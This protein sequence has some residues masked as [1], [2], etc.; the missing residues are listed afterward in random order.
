MALEFREGTYG[1]YYTNTI[2]TSQA[3]NYQQMSWNAVYIYKS[4]TEKGYSLNAICAMLGNF[5]AESTINPGRWQGNNVGG[6]P[7]YGLAQWDPYSKY[8]DWCNDNNLDPTEMDSAIARIEYEYNNHIQ[9]YATDTYPISFAQFKVSEESLEYLTQAWV[10]N[11]ERPAVKPQPYRNEYSK[12]WYD[13]LKD[14]FWIRV[15]VTCEPIEGGTVSGAG[16]YDKNSSVTVS[17][18]TNTGYRFKYWKDSNQNIISYDQTYTFTATEDINLIAVLDD[19]QY[20]SYVTDPA[21]AGTTEGSG[22]YLPNEIVSFKLTLNRGYNFRRVVDETG[23]TVSI[24]PDFK[25][26]VGTEPKS[27]KA[28]CIKSS[29]I[30]LNMCKAVRGII[31]R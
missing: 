15:N 20:L 24:K 19:L 23:T 6:G 30:P 9:Y 4:L 14:T 25:Y 16:H 11:Y 21:E 7:A 3:L 18:T 29:L 13:Y 22:Y 26:T 27:F 8:I 17:V 1:K 12:Y 5:Q 10:Y 31:V 28:I 2:D